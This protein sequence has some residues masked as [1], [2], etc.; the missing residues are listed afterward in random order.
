[1]HLIKT[2]QHFAL[3]YNELELMHACVDHHKRRI[4]IYVQV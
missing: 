2:K 3:L 4:D 1:M